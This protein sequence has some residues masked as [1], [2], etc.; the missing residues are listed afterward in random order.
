M[1]SDCAARFGLGV[2]PA[3][4]PKQTLYADMMGSLVVVRA[5]LR[6]VKPL[7]AHGLFDG[8]A[9]TL[10]SMRLAYA[11]VHGATEVL[12]PVLAVEIVFGVVQ[13]LPW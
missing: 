3:L 10:F 2:L 9:R 8:A 12:W 13:F 4:D 1:H 11:L 7:P 5:L 6:I